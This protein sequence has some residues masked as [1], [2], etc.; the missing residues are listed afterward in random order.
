[1]A[2]ARAGENSDVLNCP[3]KLAVGTPA[4]TT[5]AGEAAASD[6]DGFPVVALVLIIVAIFILILVAAGVV[7]KQNQQ[8]HNEKLAQMAY[9]SRNGGQWG[10][11]HGSSCMQQ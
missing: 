2:L 7:F 11:Q 5:V 9:E 3:W 6:S 1:V 4:A 10:T 8:K